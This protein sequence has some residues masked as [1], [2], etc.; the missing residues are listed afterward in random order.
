L[1]RISGWLPST[2]NSFYNALNTVL[3][4]AIIIWIC[5]VVIGVAEKDLRRIPKL[6]D[7]NRELIQKFLQIIIY[8]IAAAV[9]LDKMGPRPYHSRSV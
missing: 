3:T 2:Y 8:G 6:W 1:S 7:A 4:I 9:A 5:A